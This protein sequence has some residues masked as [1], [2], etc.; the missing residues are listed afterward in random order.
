MS[1]YSPSASRILTAATAHFAQRGYDGSSLAEIAAAAGIRKASLYA[2]FENKD[3]LFMQSYM[4]SRAQELTLLPAEFTNAIAAVPGMCYC[5]QLIKRYAQSASLQLFL[6]TSYTPPRALTPQIDA[7]HEEYLALLHNHFISSL[8]QTAPAI[9]NASI[10]A[11]AY[12][13]IV[14]S[15]QVKLIYTDA[16]QATQRLHAMQYLMQTCLTK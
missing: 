1:I 8:K 6:R 12:L 16:A 7:A 11:E 5:Q 10:Y 15:I 9:E 14:D 2:H 4:L 3:M 13:G